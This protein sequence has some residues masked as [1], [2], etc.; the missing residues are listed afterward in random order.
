MNQEAPVDYMDMIQ[1]QLKEERVRMSHMDG[2]DPVEIRKDA[3]VDY[4]AVAKAW[5]DELKGKSKV[6][7][8]EKRKR[9]P[10]HDPEY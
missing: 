4:M 3:P 7:L 1:Q 5:D 9:N 10:S 6:H 8:Q 2:P